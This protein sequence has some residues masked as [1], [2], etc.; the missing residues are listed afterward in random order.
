M[1]SIHGSVAY[2]AALPP[3]LPP[4]FPIYMPGDEYMVGFG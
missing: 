3:S 1:E 2:K 4:Y